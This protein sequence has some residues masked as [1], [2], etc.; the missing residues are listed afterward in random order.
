M[1][2]A[3]AAFA[4][5]AQDE[6][7]ACPSCGAGDAA[8]LQ[9]VMPRQQHLAYS[10]GDARI[11]ERLDELLPRRTE[12]YRMLQCRRCCLEFSDPLLA[13]SV[14]WYATLYAH[15]NLYPAH[16]WEYGRVADAMRAGD[17]VVDYGCGSGHFLESIKARVRR[18]HGFDFSEAAV[19]QAM[20]H[21]IDARVLDSEAEAP[22][23][24]LAGQAQHVVAFHVLEHLPD[25]AAL[26]EFASRVTTLAGQLWVAVPS[27]RRSSR[28][29]GEPDALD[30][31]PHHLTRW[32][33]AAMRALGARCGWNL[34][35]HEYE[36]LA[37]RLRVWETTRRLALYRRMNSRS[38]PVTWAYRR[39]LAA[40]V[41]LSWRHRRADLSGFSMLACFQRAQSS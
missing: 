41:W 28:R 34:V 15:L 3:A 12:A 6:A 29:F 14:D 17:T 26:F 39:A 18:V 40:G 31:P 16:R 24:D 25:P 10:G 38:R 30:G 19:A 35:R 11:A 22:I 13:P 21:G 33:E 2:L 5:G 7:R 8:L 32:T 4:A 27:D 37:T 20:D 23:A 1:T 9:Q 36:P